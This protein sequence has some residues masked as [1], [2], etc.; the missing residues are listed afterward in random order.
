MFSYR[1]A[2]H[3]GNHADVLKH[4]IWVALLS[5]AQQ[6][7]KGLMVI[8]T[9]AGA[10]AYDLQDRQAL[11]SGESQAGI[12]RVWVDRRG[13]PALIRDYLAQLIRH[14]HAASHVAAEKSPMET[15]ES[16]PHP[17]QLRFYPGSCQL[18]AQMLRTQDHLRLHELHP[19]DA[20]ALAAHFKNMTGVQVLISDGLS[21]LKAAVPPATRRATVLI[22]PPYENKN[23]Y[24]DV[25]STL[26][27]ALGKFPQGVYAVWYPVLA[28]YENQRFAQQLR[29]LAGELPWLNARLQVKGPSADGLGLTTSAMFVINPPWTLA[30]A[31][32]DAMPWLVRCL[33][34][35][36][37]ASHALDEQRV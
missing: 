31:L 1:H 15:I 20:K 3:A 7:P 6:K 16:L 14:H 28:R 5:H 26:K 27:A 18:A 4:A 22:D 25:V 33:G 17:Q 2:F 13:A 10:G 29:A 11:T 21:G 24:A 32:R 36:A 23:D 9:H 8:D 12:H 35:D 30:D 19:T 37:Q 34:Q